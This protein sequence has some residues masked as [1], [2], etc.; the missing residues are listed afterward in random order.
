MS[1]EKLGRAAFTIICLGWVVSL[2]NGRGNENPKDEIRTNNNNK[3]KKQPVLLYENFR[4]SLLS[5]KQ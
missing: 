5:L 1:L 3:K 2:D 4:I